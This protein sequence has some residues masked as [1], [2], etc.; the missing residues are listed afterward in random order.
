MQNGGHWI[1]IAKQQS[2]KIKARLANQGYFP[3]LKHKAATLSGFVA[4]IFD[5][6]LSFMSKNKR[7]DIFETLEIRNML[8]RY[9]HSFSGVPLL[10]VGLWATLMVSLPPGGGG[11]PDVAAAVAG[12]NGSALA[13]ELANQTM[14]FTKVRICATVENKGQLGN[15]YLHWR[16]QRRCVRN[17]KIK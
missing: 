9:V 10:V 15:F 3:S 1:Q 11:A 13:E 16:K 8:W 17:I 7:P 14:D 6:I 12:N 4:M 2:Q 5:P